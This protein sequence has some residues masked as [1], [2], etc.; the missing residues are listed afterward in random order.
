MK[1]VLFLFSF[2]LV[3]Q[4]GVLWAQNQVQ[5]TPGEFD[6]GTTLEWDK[7]VVSGTD[8]L[9]SGDEDTLVIKGASDSCYSKVLYNN[10]SHSLQLIVENGT[11]NRLIFEVQTAN[12]PV[13]GS[14]NK[15]AASLPDS[16]FI[17][18]QWLK[19]GT[20]V[21][22]NTISTSF[23][24]VTSSGDLK[25]TPIQLYIE[26]AQVFRLLVRSTVDQVGSPRILVFYFL[27]K[28]DVPR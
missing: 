3:V 11:T 14:L 27:N 15:G 6:F 17:A 26:N 19:N 2:L 24:S 9:F 20:G 10:G 16:F 12:L 28:E 1:R 4:T 7:K 5:R 22:G 21:A 23:D 18:S 13:G 8:S 25:T